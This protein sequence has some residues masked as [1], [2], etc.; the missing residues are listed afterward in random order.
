MFQQDKLEEWKK[1]TAYFHKFE[2]QNQ[3][4]NS[5]ETTKAIQRVEYINVSGLELVIK[6]IKDNL[7]EKFKALNMVLLPV[8]YNYKFYDDIVSKHHASLCRIGFLI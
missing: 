4:A 7:I 5:A 6:S 1:N 3:Y 8:R 2:Y